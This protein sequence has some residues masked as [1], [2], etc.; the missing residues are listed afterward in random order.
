MKKLEYLVAYNKY[1]DIM[2]WLN[3]KGHRKARNMKRINR[4]IN[5]WWC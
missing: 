3:I 5:K 1:D 4:L 2:R